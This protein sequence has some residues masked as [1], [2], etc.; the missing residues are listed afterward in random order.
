M[1]MGSRPIWPGTPADDRLIVRSIPV[2]R[3]RAVLAACEYGPVFVCP[4]PRR[5]S[6]LPFIELSSNELCVSVAVVGFAQI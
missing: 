5:F 1:P 4:D 6:K 3:H 2:I